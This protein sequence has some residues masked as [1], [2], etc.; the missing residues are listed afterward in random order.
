[1]T[2]PPAAS[3]AFALLGVGGDDVIEVA[4][5]VGVEMV[6][7]GSAGD[8]AVGGAGF[9]NAALDE[10][11]RERPIEAHAA[12]RSIHGLSDAEAERPEMAAEGES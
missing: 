7:A 11:E 5:E 1:M 6:C 2:R 4:R 10:L 9:S 12:L 3:T 8:D